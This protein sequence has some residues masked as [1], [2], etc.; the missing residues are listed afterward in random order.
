MNVKIQGKIVPVGQVYDKSLFAT[1]QIK[2]Y[3]RQNSPEVVYTVQPGG[4]VG[5]VYSHVM[6]GLELWWMFYDKNGK[7]YYAKHEDGAFSWQALQ[8]QG[9]KTTDEIVKE[10]TP[11]TALDSVLE[12]ASNLIKPAVIAIAAYYAIKAFQSDK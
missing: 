12:T 5:V 11:K 9:T 7:A 4:H 2:L 10:Q 3:R 6:N 8:Q 1:K